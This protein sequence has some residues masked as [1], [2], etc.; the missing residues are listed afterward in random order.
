MTNWRK[1]VAIKQFLK[2]D[3]PDTQEAVQAIGNKIADVLE[4]H[5]EFKHLCAKFRNIPKG[6]DDFTPIN[7][8]DKYLDSVYDIADDERIWIE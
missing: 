5:P 1:K 6:D 3:C 8:L 2:E 4:Q 7:Y